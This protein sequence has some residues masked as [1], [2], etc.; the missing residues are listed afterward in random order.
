MQDCFKSTGILHLSHWKKSRVFILCRGDTALRNTQY[1]ISTV[2]HF[3]R[4]LFCW[5]SLA[6]IK[7]VFGGAFH[8]SSVGLT[9]ESMPRGEEILMKT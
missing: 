8:D 1:L 6:F 3:Q 5:R 9:Q 4:A 7:G 2:V